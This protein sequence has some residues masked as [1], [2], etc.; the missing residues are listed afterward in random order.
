LDASPTDDD[1]AN[2]LRGNTI[3]LTSVLAKPTVTPAAGG[4]FDVSAKVL[5]VVMEQLSAPPT[6]T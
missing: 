5:R 4:T 6:R 1:M 3:N 2:L